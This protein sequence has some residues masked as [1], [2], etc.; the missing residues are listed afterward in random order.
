MLLFTF[1]VLVPYLF[2]SKHPQDVSWLHLNVTSTALFHHS[3]RADLAS[4]R[5]CFVFVRRVLICLAKMPSFVLKHREAAAF[6]SLQQTLHQIR[7]IFLETCVIAE[8]TSSSISWIILWTTTTYI[9]QTLIVSISRN[10]SVNRQGENIGSDWGQTQLNR[11]DY[12]LDETWRI[13]FTLR[14]YV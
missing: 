3:H 9:Y 4:V 12:T 8:H 6:L 11:T 7:L 13:K 10:R 1:S 5:L 14:L 2:V